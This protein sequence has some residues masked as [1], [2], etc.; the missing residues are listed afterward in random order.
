MSPIAAVAPSTPPSSHGRSDMAQ[1]DLR[2][3]SP[4]VGASRKGFMNNG[5]PPLGIRTSPV[6]SSF[7]QLPQSPSSGSTS[8]TASKFQVFDGLRSGVDS[9]ANTQRRRSASRDVV[10]IEELDAYVHL[11]QSKSSTLAPRAISLS[12]IRRW[13]VNP[14]NLGPHQLVL[15]IASTGLLW[16]LLLYL[17]CLLTSTPSNGLFTS[18]FARPRLPSSLLVP[19]SYY[20]DPSPRPGDHHPNPDPRWRAIKPLSPP[21]EPFPRLRATRFM[22]DHCLESWFAN[23]EMMCSRGE[24][25]PE[26]LLDVTWLWV[27]GSDPRWRKDML[28]WRRESKV[29]SPE[30]HWR[31]NNELKFSM[32]SVIAA[33]P[34]RLRTLH[35]IVAD[36][37]FVS[38]TDMALIAP[39]AIDELESAQASKRWLGAAASR[40]TARLQRSVADAGSLPGKISQISSQLRRWLDSEWRVAQ[41]P[42]WLAANRLDLSDAAHPLHHLR[43][44]VSKHS[45]SHLHIDSHPS[46][47]LVPHSE[48]FHLPNR[49]AEEAWRRDAL[50]SF[51]SMAIESRIGWV[52]GLADASLSL[53]DDFFLLK[54]HAISD[55]HSPL[56]GSV[57][58]FDDG[59]YQQIT[60]KL[61]KGWVNDAG[62]MGGLIHA[63]WMLSQR[64]PRRKRPY[65]AHAPKVVTRSMH[66][67]ASLMFERALTTS[68]RRRFRELPIGEGDVQMQWLIT[69]LKVERWR[70]ALLWTWIVA[71]VGTAPSWSEH[72][73]GGQ[74]DVWGEE[75]RREIMDLFGLTEE[76]GNVVSLEIHR[77][78][79]WTLEAE[80]VV[81]NFDNLGWEAPK[82]TQFLW[83]SMDGHV[84]PTIAPGMPADQNDRCTFDLD[85]CLGPFW[86]RRENVTADDMFKRLAF[87]NPACGD[88]LSMALV[89]ASGSLGLAAFLPP[90]DA[91]FKNGETTTRY[92]SY[93]PPP[94]LPLTATWQEADFSLA[95]VIGETSLPD[96]DIPLRIWTQ[97]LLSRY[98]Y[99]HGRSRSLFH[100]LL[101]PK[102]ATEVFE[103]IDGY[104]R[105]GSILG[106]N[107]D[108]NDDYETTRDIMLKWFKSKW[109]IPSVWEREWT[110]QDGSRAGLL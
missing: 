46:M 79:R 7:R 40:A 18:L 55:F 67:E 60:P 110:R 105:D 8:A 14:L 93:V 63:N 34:S 86:T 50:P 88:C 37:P 42:T 49:A 94:H 82:E 10:P 15:R 61:D 56:Y 3:F 2:S 75:A 53:N 81:G 12:R 22:P 101:N 57:F 28:H 100:M 24:V 25:G 6:S 85:R 35:L 76:D 107:D 99:I 38:E 92:E 54:P 103:S 98:Q 97:K 11:L 109:P 91:V 31:E 19:S 43:V 108:I 47:R 77:G 104:D 59:Y 62:E 21:P 33:M 102:H 90:S 13:L 29:A 96:E 95:N 73:L 87:A 36:A 70:E 4:G 58:R 66:H 26:D 65:F 16:S 48:I 5:T 27:N 45:E 83:S 20:P 80:R 17:L 68:S 52:W 23:G 39:E 1:N 64:F 51:N 32:R 74:V 44:N 78:E 9:F 69:Q 41:V 71:R 84:P 30:H 106:L 72:P 89:T